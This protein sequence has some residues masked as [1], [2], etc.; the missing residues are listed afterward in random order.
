[1]TREK[2]IEKRPYM[3]HLTSMEN[4]EN[5]K[6]ERKL[7]S[8]THLINLSDK[9]SEKKTELISSK[10]NCAITISANGT[11]VNIRD[12]QPISIKAL[13]KC[14]TDNMTVE[15]Y[16]Q[17]LNS[18]VFFWPTKDRLG[19]HY[20]RYREEDIV[21]LRVSTQDLFDHNCIFLRFR[22]LN[23]AESGQLFPFK[24]DT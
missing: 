14:L 15:E 3:Y 1:M 9:T 20:K 6:N 2:F 22:T 18:R 12:Q 10:R 16:I 7:F 4:F 17:L 5:I 13:G 24:T 19:R 21:I 11:N 23:P 8:A